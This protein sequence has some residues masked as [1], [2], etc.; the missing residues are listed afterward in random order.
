MEEQSSETLTDVRWHAILSNNASYD[1]VFFYAVKTTGIFCRPSCK[2][3][4]PNKENIAIYRTAEQALSAHFRPCKRCKPTGKRL[5]DD[6]WIHLAAEYIDR[7]YMNNLTLQVVADHCHGSPYHLHRTFKKIKHI[8]PVEYIQQIRVNKAKEQLISS[9]LTISEIGSSVGLRNTPYFVT[10]FRKKTGCT[11][12]T[13][14]QLQKTKM[15]EA[16]SNDQPH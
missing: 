4:P 2:S 16:H 13:Y 10:L 3:K 6:E 9:D 5:P 1:G 15:E 8:T 12:A 14:R 7:N 11:P